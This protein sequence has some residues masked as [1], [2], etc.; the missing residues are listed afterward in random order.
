MKDVLKP[1]LV[2]IHREG[3]AFIALA[4][5]L[6]AVAAVFS[7]AFLF[8]GIPLT[9]WVVYFFRDPDRTTPVRQGLV[10]SPADGVV[11][12]V[13]QAPPPP[14]LEMGD[15]PMLRIATFMNV[16]DVHV[17]RA[18]C[19][20]TVIGMHYRPGKFVNADLDKASTDNE[21]QSIR[22]QTL[23][24]KEIAV[25]Q[26]AGLVARRIL[27]DVEP[28][29]DLKAGERFGMIRFG[30]RVDVYLPKTVTALVCEG[31]RMIAGE[32]VMA[33]LGGGPRGKESARKG[34]VR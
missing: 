15:K 8:I 9:A 30:S 2:P 31:Q 33:D 24:G 32:T 18:P 13:T 21:R 27:C 34:E 19:D 3:W 14:E 1:V 20:G 11:C 28:G 26:I 16:F 25:V 12:S 29:D 10:V 4:A 17:N 22:M 7:E 5:I 23:N 6:T